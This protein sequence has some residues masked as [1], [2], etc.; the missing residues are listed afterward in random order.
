MDDELA[1]ALEELSKLT[2]MSVSEL[3]RLAIL[4]F[5]QSVDLDFLSVK[6]AVGD[7]LME[8]T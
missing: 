7:D 1:Q 2:G 6:N 5:V 4:E 8:S 3:I